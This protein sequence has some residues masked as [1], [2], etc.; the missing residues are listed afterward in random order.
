MALTLLAA[1]LI[2]ANGFVLG[3]G[4]LFFC[5]FIVRTRKEEENLL[6]RFGDPYRNY[7]ERTGRFLPR[8]AHRVSG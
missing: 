8:S 5:L 3:A 2:M 6:A 1:G 4:S 7:M